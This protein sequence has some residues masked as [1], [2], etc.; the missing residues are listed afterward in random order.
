M[1][2]PKHWTVQFDGGDEKHEYCVT[3]VA[4]ILAHAVEEY[5]CVLDETELREDVME[6]NR[7]AVEA[8][9]AAVEPVARRLARRKY[10]G[11]EELEMLADAVD[12]GER[13]AARAKGR[14]E[15]YE[16]GWRLCVTLRID[17]DA[18]E[19]AVE[20]VL[21][22]HGLPDW[23]VEVVDYDSLVE[24]LKGDPTPLPSLDSTVVEWTGWFSDFWGQ[25][26]ARDAD[27]AQQWAR[28]AHRVAREL[29]CDLY[30]TL[31]APWMDKL[32]AGPNDTIRVACDGDMLNVVASSILQDVWVRDL[33]V[34]QQTQRRLS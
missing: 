34:W 33:D 10:I 15:P 30:E 5:D 6:Q 26:H 23:A 8:Y 14:R 28:V 3:D 11:P 17:V 13:A 1:S 29:A 20:T 12:A 32:C 25:P 19:E 18:L 9:R 24:A 7:E 31:R 27:Q 4:R 22:K 16:I 21:K 2:D